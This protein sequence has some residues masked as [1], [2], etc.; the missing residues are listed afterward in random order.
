MREASQQFN[1]DNK[2]RFQETSFHG[3][4]VPVTYNNF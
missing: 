1:E 2:K 4:T 3:M